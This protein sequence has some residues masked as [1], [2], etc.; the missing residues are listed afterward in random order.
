[1]VCQSMYHRHYCGFY[2]VCGWRDV[3]VK[4]LL[5]QL[6]S[7]HLSLRTILLFHG[8][9]IFYTFYYITYLM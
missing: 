5:H 4:S 8:I 9:F 1:M 6:Y 7:R 3:I 2:C